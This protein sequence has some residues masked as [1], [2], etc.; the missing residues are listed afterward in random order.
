M[1]DIK[2]KTQK[3]K[4][5]SIKWEEYEYEYKPKDSNWYWAVAS[6]GL[7]LLIISILTHNFLLGAFSVITTFTL[8]VY[9]AKKPKRLAYVIDA[10]GIKMGEK[11][12]S[13]GEIKSFW[14]NYDPP[15]KKELIFALQKAIHPLVKIPLGGTD[16]NEART[17]L[18]KFLK[19]KKE[20]ESL[21]ETI[22]EL[23]GF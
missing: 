18:L 9:G 14:I 10:R 6:G 23:L 1:K 16:P 15:H 3:N 11:I 22:G 8:S 12:Y 21:I 2:D 7:A 4:S 13:Y 20:E 5:L 19:E 17:M